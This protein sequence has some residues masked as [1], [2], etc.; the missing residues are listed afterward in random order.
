MKSAREVVLNME[1]EEAIAFFKWLLELVKF[2]EVVVPDN[3]AKIFGKY[4]NG[5]SVEIYC[6]NPESEKAQCL[7]TSDN[8]TIVEAIEEFSFKK[9]IMEKWSKARKELFISEER[10]ELHKQVKKETTQRPNQNTD[11]G[12]AKELSIF[13]PAMSDHKSF[14][15]YVVLPL[16][17]SNLQS[18]TN[19]YSAIS[20]SGHK[21]TFKYLG[22]F[23]QP[24]TFSIESESQE[25]LEELVSYFSDP[26]VAE[27]W[28]DEI[29][30]RKARDT[31]RKNVQR[32][33]VGSTRSVSAPKPSRNTLS[34][35]HCGGHKI[36]L[37]ANDK[38]TRN[39]TTLNL[40]PL[41]P[42]TL[43]KTEKK[44]KVHKG[45][46]ALAVVTLG[47]SAPFT[48]IK[49]NKNN[50]YFCTDCGHRWT[51]K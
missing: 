18:K 29:A 49:N 39:K 21:A 2:Q 20:P 44:K 24:L 43:V 50:E 16:G 14:F 34:C 35:P 22:G 10:Q 19:C 41:E 26:N 51:G 28:K 40:N 13:I 23:R 27:N 36:Q 30:A 1:T 5:D 42:F 8:S 7:I 33:A 15:L 12:K 48:G 31:Q 45:K 46:A 11:T 6:L 25:E 4:T 32:Q 9:D 47:T 38:N 37:I 3:G 17:Y